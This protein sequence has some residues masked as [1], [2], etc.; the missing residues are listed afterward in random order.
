MQYIYVYI[1]IVS[2]IYATPGDVSNLMLPAA[3]EVP[4]NLCIIC[5]NAH[6]VL[7]QASP[8]SEDEYAQGTK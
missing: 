4:V 7:S 6:D 1:P 3:R 2:D 8:T 5:P